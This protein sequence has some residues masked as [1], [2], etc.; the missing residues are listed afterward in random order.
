MNNKPM[1][2]RGRDVGWCDKWVN[3]FGF[4]FLFK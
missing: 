2:A 1:F 4:T 3:C